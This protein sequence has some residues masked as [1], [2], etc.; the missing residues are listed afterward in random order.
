MLSA[1]AQAVFVSMNYARGN[2]DAPLI[3]ERTLSNVAMYGD[4]LLPSGFES[5]NEWKGTRVS[6]HDGFVVRLF[7]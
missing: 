3:F 7:P 2:V 4:D 1:A 5:T 6:D